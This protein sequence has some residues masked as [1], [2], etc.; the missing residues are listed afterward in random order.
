MKDIFFFLL[1]L[2]FSSCNSQH[3]Y[4]NI[5]VADFEKG[6]RQPGAQLIDVRSPEEYKEKHI[7]E[8]TNININ[9][10]NFEA[11]INKL[12]K[13]KPLYLYCLAGSRSAKA[14][15]LAKAN[16]F[17]LVYNL[18]G[19]INSWIKETKPV[20]NGNGEKISGGSG[21]SF[22]DYLNHLKNSDKLVLVDF[23]AVWCGPCKILK[24]IVQRV[25][26]KNNA[27][28]EL[29]DID[30]DQNN[31]VANTMNVKGIPF[32]LIYKQGKEV[33][34]NMGLIEE[35]DLQEKVAELLQ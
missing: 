27:K 33:W 22:D 18:E 30:V 11:S 25:V 32:L 12:D 31:I 8:A 17:T 34:R 23:N 35:D 19:G 13:T 9:G 26:K 2:F 1:L 20:V 3:P 24:P 21:M 7:A 16:G 15:E 5:S 29:F 28:I 6:L 14:A 4:K 10:D